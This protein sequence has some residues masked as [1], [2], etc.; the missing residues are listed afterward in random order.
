LPKLIR[1]LCALILSLA[2]A[3]PAAAFAPDDEELARL[4]R[5]QYGGLASWEAVMTFPQWPGV[6]AHVWQWRGHWRQEWTFPGVVGETAVESVPTTAAAVGMDGRVVAACAGDGFALSPLLVWLPVDPVAAWRAWGV[7]TAERSYGFCSEA[8]CL[9]LGAG[10]GDDTLPAVRLHNEDMAPLMLRYGA[11]PEQ[12]TL[13]FGEYLTVGGFR[14]PARLTVELG[15]TSLEAEVKWLA[16]NRAEGE[17]LYAR[18]TV[19]LAPCAAPPS[20]FVILR[21]HFRYPSVE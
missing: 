9:M 3:L 18:D 14:L 6:S 7:E 2:A 16:V 20:P 5:K 21:D 11:G 19:D 10:P 12:V 8:P 17:E 15:Q 13:R 4:M 1:F